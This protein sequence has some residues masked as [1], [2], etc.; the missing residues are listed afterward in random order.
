[1]NLKGAQKIVDEWAQQFEKPY[2]S[3]LEQLAQ[4]LEEAGEL[5]R[6]IQHKEGRKKLKKGEIERNLGEELSDVLLPII[7]IANSQKID[8]EEAFYKMVETRLYGR[9]NNRYKKK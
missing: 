8:L 4:L 3:S 5:S 6:L 1:M 2:F 7:C 9:D